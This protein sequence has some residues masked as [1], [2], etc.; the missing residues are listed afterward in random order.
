MLQGNGLVTHV[1]PQEDGWM[2]K[3]IIYGR[4]RLSRG[5][6][7][8]MRSGGAVYLNGQPAYITQRGQTGDE[9]AIEFADSQSALEPEPIPLDIVYEDSSVLVVNKP[10]GLAV[11]P[12]RTYPAGTLA[13]GIAA[14]WKERGYRRR[15]RL[16]H[17]LDRETSGLLMVAK[18]PYAYQRLSLQFQDGTLKRRYLALVA[19]SL[20]EPSGTICQPIGRQLGGGGHSLR[21]S[22]ATDGRE[23]VTHYEL[24][25]RYQGC[26]LVRL[27]LETGRTHQ[28][29]VH[30]AW[31]GH[32]LLGDDMYGGPTQWFNRQ[33][34]H[35]YAMEFVHP[36]SG[37]V[38]KLR[39]PVPAD[40][41][42]LL[43]ERKIAQ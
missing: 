20:Q 42:Q 22:V 39:V 9:L 37:L 8:R 16:L 29:R 11:H 38:V 15:V 14:L 31:L 43:L 33:A 32:P 12:T 27:S 4:L 18:E 17:R 25:Q 35:A 41:K 24:L 5:L 30:M 7:R 3:E 1:R 21:R 26:S 23:A 13:N 2:L 19:G 40:M 6:L 36:R 34:L 28:I 10:A